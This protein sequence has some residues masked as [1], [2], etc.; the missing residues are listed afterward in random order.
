MA[1]HVDAT[2]A[3]AGGTT[4]SHVALV[5]EP[6]LPPDMPRSRQKTTPRGRSDEG[7]ALEPEASKLVSMRVQA[8]SAQTSTR[9]PLEP[10]PSCQRKVGCRDVENE[11]DAGARG[12][13]AATSGV[14]SS[15]ASTG[16]PWEEEDP[17]ALAAT[18]PS[19]A[20]RTRP[21]KMRFECMGEKAL[22]WRNKTRT[23]STP[24]RCVGGSLL[25]P[26][27]RPRLAAPR[28]GP[29]PPPSRPAWV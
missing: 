15:P 24:T 22:L 16:G 21:G 27:W 11:A 8:R 6:A 26:C 5:A 9:A 18:K 10:A 19:A 17:Q 13:G 25:L 14:L 4:S 23:T 20:G 7:T 3:D 12:R 29:R 28:P 2:A 1:P